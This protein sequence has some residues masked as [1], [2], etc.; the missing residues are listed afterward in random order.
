MLENSLIHKF[1]FKYSINKSN[2]HI[3]QLIDLLLFLLFIICWLFV[4]YILI[5]N[6]SFTTHIENNILIEYNNFKNKT[7][8]SGPYHVFKSTIYIGKFHCDG[9]QNAIVYYPSDGIKNSKNKYPLI[10]F[11]HGFHSGGNKLDNDYSKLLVGLASWGFII[12]APESAPRSYCQELYQDQ[13]RVFDYIENEGKRKQIFSSLDR[14]AK[15]GVLGHSM[16][17]R[18]TIICS[19][20]DNYN[21]G[22]AAALNPVYTQ[23]ASHVKVKIYLFIFILI[24]LTNE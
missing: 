8:I 22:A 11:G 17:G 9:N 7:F 20:K 6:T 19:T 14:S 5:S 16:G 3:K 23:A 18:S 13:L 12:V 21:I 24:N 4:G 1:F 15:Y 10:S 2:K